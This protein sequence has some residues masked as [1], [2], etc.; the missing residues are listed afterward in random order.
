MNAIETHGLT[1]NYTGFTLDALDLT[2]P[3]G[4]IVGLIGENGA[5]KTTTIKTLLG[6]IQPDGGSAEVMDCSIGE[7]M[8]DVRNDIGVVLDEPGLPLCFTVADTGKVMSGIFKT[9]DPALYDKLI[10]KLN[11]PRDKTY[12]EMSR[13]TRMKLGIAVA[14]AH[15]PRLLIMDEPTS[16]LDPVVRD[17]VVDLFAR[18][19]R[20]PE[21][22]ILISSHIVSDLEKLCD[23]IAFIHKG[24]LM[25]FEEKDT[26][27]SEYGIVHCTHDEASSIPV[28]AVLRKKETPYGVEAIVQ[29]KYIPGGMR[30]SPVSIEELFIHMVK[31]D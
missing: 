1:K 11:V 4:C 12:Q 20:N 6:M 18:F 27:L 10:N 24:K 15:R 23:Y 19:T 21:H 17:E 5:G 29:R 2:V 31:E 25:L 30:A 13:G 8:T 26:L 3:T 14:I 22:S 16:G 9:W 7:D 28:F